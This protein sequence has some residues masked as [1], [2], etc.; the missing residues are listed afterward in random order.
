MSILTILY[1]LIVNVPK[2]LTNNVSFH[3]LHN[4]YL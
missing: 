1:I 3:L 2:C 4:Y